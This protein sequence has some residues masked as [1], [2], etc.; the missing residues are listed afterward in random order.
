MILLFCTTD[1]WRIVDFRKRFQGSQETVSGH[2]Q[3]CGWPGMTMAAMLFPQGFSM[4]PLSV[5]FC[6]ME[7][8]LYRNFIISLYYRLKLQFSS[9]LLFFRTLSECSNQSGLEVDR[10]PLSPW[11]EG[12]RRVYFSQDE[13]HGYGEEAP[14]VEKRGSSESGYCT[15]TSRGRTTSTSDNVFL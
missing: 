13:E 1:T 2:T 7:E 6:K 3:I 12:S 5:P 8:T 15:T 11:A 14:L 10:S 4:I 9:Q